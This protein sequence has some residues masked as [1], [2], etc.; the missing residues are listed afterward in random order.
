[1]PARI[2]YPLFWLSFAVITGRAAIGPSAT[3]T[4]ANA[5]ISPDGFT[6]AASV[7]NGAHPGPVITA[8]TGET[9]KLNVVNQL[10]DPQQERGTSIHWHGLFQHGTNFMDGTVGVTQCPIAPGKSFEYSFKADRPGT[11]WY[12]SHFGLQYCDGLRGPI[13]IYDPDDPLKR[14][15]DVDDD[16]T[17]ITLSEWYH[18]LAASIPG[19]PAADSTLINGRG[20]Y[21]GGPASDL[22][23]VNV[24]KGKRYRLRL[25]SISC[26]PFF[27]F[28]I[29]GHDLQ[30]IEVEGAE[31]KP[32]T[33]NSIKIL[34]GQ[35]YSMV[36]NA[37][38]SVGNYWIRSLPSSGNGILPTSFDG[39]INSAI[40]RYKG[41]PQTEPTSTQQSSIKALAETDLHPLSNP[42]AP[43]KP[44]PDGA[45][46]TV[47]LTFGFDPA[48]VK[49]NVNGAVFEPPTVP[50]LLQILSGARNAQDLLP[51]GGVITVPKDK[52]IQINVPSGLIGGP[53]PFHMH[54]HDFSV[55]KVADAGHFN[56]LD[57][58]RRD[59]TNMG[60]TEG[61]FIS[62]RFK[63]DNPGPWI[64]HCH[65][66]FHL[67]AGLAIVFAEAPDEIPAA[68][69][70][71]STWKDLCPTWDALPDDVKHPQIS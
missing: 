60:E 3:L 49:Y 40:L 22:S 61:D 34:A 10:A 70:V 19:I 24:Q 35:R 52:V 2:G 16:S 23:V 42:F 64:F 51:S 45:D 59:V 25:I 21:P 55:V 13:V 17:V 50:V 32:I 69:P 66:D 43:G 30:V 54:G 58:V 62:I 47:N 15:Y 1:M 57:P 48:V 71:P 26:D 7:V 4:V 36:L 18:T 14:L 63:T 8:K 44:A 65:V 53:H 46:L 68:D 41:A 56:F 29:D 38:Q 6:R 9:F 27:T 31:V 12:H 28:S 5:N 39:G 67:A 37:S 33:V 20:R 11:F